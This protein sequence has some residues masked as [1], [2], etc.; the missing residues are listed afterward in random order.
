M[1]KMVV[2]ITL[3]TLLALLFFSTYSTS[4]GRTALAPE[5]AQ[6]KVTFTST[7]S[8]ETHPWPNF[9]PGAHFSRL[10]GGTHNQNVAFWTRDELATDGIKDMAER[11]NN[12]NLTNEV[13]AQITA[14]TADQYISG[15]SLGTS[16]GMIVIDSVD[17]HQ[18]YPLLTLVSMIAPSPDW[19]VGVSGVP[20]FE[21]GDWVASKEIT[22]FPYDAG[23]DDGI[24]YGSDDAPS[25]PRENIRRISDEDPFSEEPIGMLTLTRINIPEPTATTT[26]VDTATATATITP[27]SNLDSDTHSDD[28]ANLDSIA[29]THHCTSRYSDGNGYHYANGNLNSDTHS[30]DVANLDSIANAHHLSGWHA[31]TAIDRLHHID[32]SA[33]ANH[34]R[35]YRQWRR[36][37][38][39]GTDGAVH[40][41]RRFQLWDAGRHHG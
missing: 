13:E 41:D 31:R 26:P 39:D 4:R 28:V 37:F 33:L 36:H 20:L 27:N 24:D 25:T 8:N 40:G 3:A 2:S 5:T 19:F 7:W 23:T 32:R 18:E 16:T 30:D 22:L 29:D 6:Y 15:S 35:A 10:V 9:P 14:G 1:K 21:G 12:T 38:G 34:R 11:G 17:V